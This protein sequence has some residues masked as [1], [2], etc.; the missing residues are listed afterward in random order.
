ME[1]ILARHLDVLEDQVDASEG[2]ALQGLLGGGR[3]ACVNVLVGL[4]DV[5]QLV[6]GRGF[7]V[8]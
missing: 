8:R 6:P 4:E 7:V 3:L 5:G 2:D 1:A